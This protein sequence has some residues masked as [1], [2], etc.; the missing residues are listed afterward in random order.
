MQ[1][2]CSSSRILFHWI[3]TKS[4]VIMRQPIV[5]DLRSKAK[6]FI[7][8]PQ[9]HGLEDFIT[10]WH[11]SCWQWH[12]I[13]HSSIFLVLLL[14]KMSVIFRLRSVYHILL[15]INNTILDWTR[16]TGDVKKTTSSNTSLPNSVIIFVAL[17]FWSIVDAASD[18]MSNVVLF[19]NSANRNSWQP[20][21][22]QSR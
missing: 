8:C 2:F 16:D 7:K 10:G 6:V 18:V 4:K 20:R 19:C 12:F 22:R 1:T 14:I 17:R 3:I 15:Y 9:G 5:K 21:R 13:M 11:W